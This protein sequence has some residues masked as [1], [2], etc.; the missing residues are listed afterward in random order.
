MMTH[1][2]ID[3]YGV[4]LTVSGEINKGYMGD[5]NHEGIPRTVNIFEIC[6]NDLN[7]QPMLMAS[8]ENEIESLILEDYD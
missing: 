1:W 4:K 3:Y 2:E 8:Q 7:I 6:A 5:Y